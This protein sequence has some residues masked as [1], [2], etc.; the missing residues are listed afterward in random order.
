MTAIPHDYAERVY[1]GV[2]GKLIGVYLGRPFEGWTYE[3]IMKELGPV[4]YYV[5]ERR[6][7][8][9]R[10]HHLVVTD[11]DVSGTFAFPRALADNGFPKR[12]T[13]EQIGQTWL[14]YL[15]E[16]RSTLWWGGLGTSTEHT[17]YL[18]LKTGVAAPQ[19]GSIEMNGKTVAEQI[20]AQIFID[21]WAM[22]SPGN[23]EQAAYLAE[24]AGRVSHD[25]EAVH[26]AKL[27]AAMEAQAFVEEDVQKLIDVG[28]AFVPRDA[29]V[30]RVV[31]DVRAWHAGDNGQHWE[32]T[33]ALI[34]ERYGYDK[35]PGH[36]HVVPNHALVI[37]ATLYGQ[38]SF[39]DAMR[40]AT[41]AGWDTD[42][43]A[44]N[45]A[46]LFGI[47][48]GLAG[49]DAGPDFRTP[50]AD[51][52]YISTADGGGS[53]TDAV[54]ETRRLVTAGHVLAG[55][56]PPAD[57]ER[58]VRFGFEF[59]GSLQAFR[60]EAGSP[61]LLH[62]VGLSNVARKSRNGGRSL[63]IT[64][65]HLAPGR[66]ARVGSPTFA[67]KEVFNMP[68]FY[69]LMASPTLYS[70]QTVE[71]GFAA[72]SENSA[73][74]SARL[75]AR[76]YN[77]R[78]NLGRVYGPHREIAPS[79]DAILQWRIPDTG[80]Y[81]I[82]DIGLELSTSASSG[83]NGCIYLDYLSWDGAP[84]LNLRR[85][86]PESTMWKHAWINNTSHFHTDYGL[87]VTSDEGLGS[88]LQGT[89]EWM[90]YSVEAEIT[91]FLAN[92]W[93]L[94]ARVQGRG[95]Y[96]GLMFDRVDSGQVRLVRR[97]HMEAILAASRFVWHPD[98]TYLIRLEVQG[99]AL[100]AFVGDRLILEAQDVEHGLRGGGVGL[101]VDTGSIFTHE[102]R[103][104]PL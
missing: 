68:T 65:S 87:W 79:G 42:C 40:I 104:R 56:Q 100:R 49:L 46:C 32:R 27:L 82:F 70:G 61:A 75:Y 12:L 88:L 58:A 103:L 19:S 4:N 71:C 31:E 76:A 83:A 15:V 39:Q 85:P 44:G 52:M 9:L 54:I 45:V 47:R 72:G 36:C 24:Q 98:Q 21:G 18:R 67:D 16:G 41:T 97:R 84:D 74:V 94:A 86:D 30:R 59:P 37:L 2:L 92:R 69:P 48:T 5:N 10:S 53:I 55:G 60:C 34:A 93:G 6:D 101:L 66:V 43:N 77:E 17:A 95:R 33:R 8:A 64:F 80:S 50:I 38:D 51:R 7:V 99:D 14:N 22:V 28:L 11:D 89:R 91:P 90:D 73:A 3:R 78:D 96:Y 13:S 62:P 26:A 57:S 35:F 81:P 63:A 1:A 102:L 29:I 23:P 20:G 25:G